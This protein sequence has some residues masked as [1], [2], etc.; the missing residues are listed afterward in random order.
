MCYLLDLKPSGCSKWD[1][2]EI[3]RTIFSGEHLRC[4]R[5][6]QNE[7]NIWDIKELSLVFLFAGGSFLT[8][9]FL[10]AFFFWIGGHCVCM[11]VSRSVSISVCGCLFVIWTVL[12]RSERCTRLRCQ[13]FWSCTNAC[14]QVGVS[15]EEIN[16]KAFMFLKRSRRL[17]EIDSPCEGWWGSLVFSSRAWERFCRFCT[18]ILTCWWLLWHVAARLLLRVGV[19]AA[20]WKTQDGLISR[21]R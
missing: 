6:Q 17:F 4:M 18:I 20:L 3:T 16:K 15:Y 12:R 7:R 9:R 8:V 10:W 21:R 19:H 1:K 13:W 2:C 11:Q 5:L 14:M